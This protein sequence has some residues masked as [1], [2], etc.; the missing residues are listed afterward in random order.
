MRLSTRAIARARGSN[1]RRLRARWNGRRKR[2]KGT[3]SRDIRACSWA[4]PAHAAGFGGGDVPGAVSDCRSLRWHS[5]L[6]HH[7]LDLEPAGPAADGV[8]D[9]AVG[10][11]HPGDVS[12][13]RTLRAAVLWHFAA[14]DQDR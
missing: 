12:V 7:D 14:R 8:Q 5:H 6:L 13:L 9:G 2:W 3:A 11:R 4:V 1:W 10:V